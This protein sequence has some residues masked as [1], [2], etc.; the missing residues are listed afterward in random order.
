MITLKKNKRG[1]VSLLLSRLSQPALFFIFI[2]A[3]IYFGVLQTGAFFDSGD[4]QPFTTTL[5]GVPLQ[6]VAT[7]KI[8][9][10]QLSDTT[11]IGNGYTEGDVLTLRS[12]TTGAGE[13]GIKVSGTFPKGTIE[14]MCDVRAESNDIDVLSYCRTTPKEIYAHANLNS[15][16]SGV[17]NSRPS[18][19]VSEKIIIQTDNTQI[20]IWLWQDVKSRYGSADGTAT[21]KFTP[22]VSG[23][24]DS[25]QETTTIEVPPTA[26]GDCPSGS[27]KDT[28]GLC[29]KPL[30]TEEPGFFE[31][32]WLKIKEI[33]GID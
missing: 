23:A 18:H 25:P 16:I 19:S 32:I 28:D 6:G 1:F 13:N 15:G 9:E 7:W 4:P 11:R 29:K 8:G 10:K 5:N 17:T 30:L 3:I 2:V 24:T 22:D 31:K 14:V 33:L 20:D 21:I 12:S 26:T 27:Y